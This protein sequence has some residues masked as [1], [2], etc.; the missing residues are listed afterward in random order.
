MVGSNLVQRN[1]F[2]GRK[3]CSQYLD[4]MDKDSVY[5][6]GD[7]DAVY[8]KVIEITERARKRLDREHGRLVGGGGGGGGSHDSLVIGEEVN[9][10]RETVDSRIARTY[11]NTVGGV[12]AGGGVGKIYESDILIVKDFGK[13]GRDRDELVCGGV[14]CSL[15]GK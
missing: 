9:N 3:Y 13:S 7:N 2:S 4:C 11:R 14:G 12:G 5:K 6:M 15:G 1:R 8:R 10:M